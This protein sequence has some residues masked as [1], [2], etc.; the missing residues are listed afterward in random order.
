METI[1]GAILAYL[2]SLAAG[3]RGGAILEKEEQEL[4][5]KLE[6]EAEALRA[7]QDRSALKD[8]LRLV[9]TEAARITA[10]AGVTDAEK[11]LFMLLNDEVFQEDMAKWLTAWR[12]VDKKEAEA[13]LAGQMVKALQRGGVDDRKIK[14]FKSGYFNRIEKVVF[15][16]PVLSNW[17]LTLALN[18]AFERLDELEAI[19]REE[20][21]ETRHEVQIQHKETRQTVAEMAAKEA[22]RQ[23]ERFSEEQREK[24]RMQR[25]KD[26][27]EDEKNRVPVGERLEKSSHMVLLG[28]PGAGKT[29]LIRWI[30][31]AYLLRLKQDPAYKDLPDVATLPGKDWLPIVIRCRDLDESCKTGSID[32]VLCETFRKAQM[33]AE[34]TAALQAVIR[35]MLVQEKAILLVDGLDEISNIGIRARFCQQIER[36]HIAFPNAPMI[37]TSR[38]VGYREMKYR[39]G[40]GFEHATVSE[41]IKKDKDE[42]A[43]RW[44][45]ITELPERRE[46]AA[47]ELMHAI[48]SSDRIERLA[49]NPMLLTTLALVKRKVGKLPERRADLYWEA[50]LVLLNWRSEVDAAIDHREAVPQLEYVAYEMCRQGVQRLREDE[51]LELMEKMREEYPN[52]R[53]AKR[54]EPGEFL[55]IL[56][57]RTGILI[58]A[59]EVRH[60]GRLVPVFEFRHLTFQEYLAALALVDG[61]FPGRDSSKSLAEHIAPLAGQIE[62]I[63][64]KGKYPEIKETLVK[65]NWREVL[66]LCAACCGDDDVD[67]VLLAIL[68]PL[69][70]EKPEET[71]RPRA[72]L[73]TLCLADELNVSDEVVQQVLGIFVQKIEKYDGGGEVITLLDTAAIELAGSEWDKQLRMF[74][75]EEFCKCEAL[76]RYFI[77][78][79]AAMISLHSAPRDNKQFQLWLAEIVGKLNSNDDSIKIDAALTIMESAFNDKIKQIIPGMVEGLLAMLDKNDP[80]AYA[81]AWALGWLSNKQIWMPK[82][83]DIEKLISF[84]SN[85]NS[86]IKAI[87]LADY[88]IGSI[89]DTQAIDLFITALNNEN[90][91]TRVVAINALENIVDSRAV[92]PLIKKLDD[93]NAAVRRAAINALRSIGDY[94]AVDPLIKKLDDENAAVRRAAINALENIGDSRAVDPLIKKLDDE[95]AEIRSSALGVLAKICV[96]EIDRKLLTGNLEGIYS[97]LDP[98]EPIDEERVKNAAIKLKMKESEVRQRY[99]RLA[100]KYKLKLSLKAQ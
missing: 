100:E 30:A 39:I 33:A 27:E 5:K 23:V 28:D 18:A 80:L 74:V 98:Q 26:E 12:P 60:K 55:R 34:E 82:P 10:K 72:V 1:I 4:N 3:L 81:G 73:A 87:R 83:K 58:E 42:F 41:F 75:V 44:C 77:G 21:L 90:S 43:R 37:V 76:N 2:I 19:I 64:T 11:P 91:R 47:E 84:I 94:H 95:N 29:T 62:L 70:G 46:K 36:L 49:G 78:S 52:V 71:A 53:A 48:H 17:R 93:E 65:D 40:R 97:W 59:G 35:E 61:K 54:H 69:P 88:I 25:I 22:R 16:D 9:G 13:V 24:M 96:D 45:D 67:D 38:I 57:R 89:K 51:I 20:G 85:P 6:K 86:D 68:T 15:K 32:D 50:V 66:R 14:Q 92:D 7:I 99:E 31:T 8:Q 63:K 56:E 79:F